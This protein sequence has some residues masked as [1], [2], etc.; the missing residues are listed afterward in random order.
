[1]TF[2]EWMLSEIPDSIE[3]IANHGA[4]G[5]YPQLTYYRD[6]VKL[7]DEHEEEIWDMLEEDRQALGSAN[8]IEFVSG[9]G[10]AGQIQSSDTFK[11][12]LVW[13]MAERT[14]Q[15]LNEAGEIPDLEEVSS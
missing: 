14:A 4:S 8:I 13:Y 1:M 3:D 9:F 10:C 2:K 12:A 11:N 15:E 7:Y 6:T 5:G